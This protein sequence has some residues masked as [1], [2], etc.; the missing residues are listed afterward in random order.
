MDERH[1]DVHDAVQIDI[2]H[3]RDL[4][5]NSKD[6]TM[7]LGPGIMFG[8]I[9]EPLYAAGKEMCKSASLASLPSANA[10]QRYRATTC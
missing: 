2:S 7:T 9:L 8:D 4:S 5:I 10:V 6:S 3:L 1:N